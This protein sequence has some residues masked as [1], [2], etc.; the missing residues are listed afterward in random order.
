ME[1]RTKFKSKKNQVFLVRA[2]GLVFV[3]K[4]FAAAENFA[5]EQ[6]VWGMLREKM[7]SVPALIAVDP[8]KKMVQYEYIAGETLLTLLERVPLSQSLLAMEALGQWLWQLHKC[9]LGESGTTVLV[10]DM[11]LRNF[12]Y[13][14]GVIYGIDYE[15]YVWGSP[16]SD[17]AGVVA[18]I[19]TYDIDPSKKEPCIAA[20]FKGYQGATLF[21]E[22]ALAAEISLWQEKLFQRRR[23]K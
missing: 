7:L 21:E 18:F 14:D 19:A 23:N 11:N 2:G 9:F 20:F 4:N 13:A 8:H 16:I 6:E 1:K 22:G 12:I 15:E 17:V 5:R 10:G 3:E